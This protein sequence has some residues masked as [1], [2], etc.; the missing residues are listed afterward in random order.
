MSVR[1]SRDHPSA[2]SFGRVAWW[3]GG[4]ATVLVGIFTLLLFL[5]LEVK[6]ATIEL[7]SNE[8]TLLK[9]RLDEKD[10]QI[11]RY[12]SIIEGKEIAVTST[13]AL[14]DNELR[15]KSLSLVSG[16]RDLLDEYDAESRRLMREE[17]IASR[18]AATEEEKARLWNKYMRRSDEARDKVMSTYNRE[19]KIDAEILHGE[20]LARLPSD[21]ADPRARH[22]FLPYGAG[23]ILGAKAV[24]DEIERLAKLLPPDI[25]LTDEERP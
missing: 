13:S 6:N 16:L 10:K 24:A 2:E 25:G 22:F 20:L 1:G 7:V 5:L 18:S 8:V 15:S 3:V 17:R 19:Y 12:V 21:T 9:E 4:T 14:L 23:N 11:A